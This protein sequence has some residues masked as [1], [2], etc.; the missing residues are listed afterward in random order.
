MFQFDVQFSGAD[1]VADKI[2]R[3]TK[4]FTVYAVDSHRAID[5]ARKQVQKDAKLAALFYP[6]YRIIGTQD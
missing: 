6:A 4:K 3:T 2:R 5:E 1:V